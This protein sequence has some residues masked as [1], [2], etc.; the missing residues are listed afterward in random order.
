MLYNPQQ[1]FE[2]ELRD[3]RGDDCLVIELL[4]PVAAEL[5]RTQR[6]TSTHAPVRAHAYLQ[7]H[8]LARHLRARHVDPLPVEELA[9]DLLRRTV[10]ASVT[11]T[12]RG[13]TRRAHRELAEALKDTLW[14]RIGE[15]VG[16]AELAR[17]LAVS[18]F[19][20]MRVFREQTGFAIHDYRLQ[21]RLRVALER[22]AEG[23]DSPSVLA[24]ELGFAS[25]SHFTRQFRRSFGIA[26]SH[27]G[28]QDCASL[29]RGAELASSM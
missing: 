21:L 12:R 3:P 10:A 19:H 14:R 22:L 25:H 5:L 2:R 18:P 1:V 17:R 7:R 26:P 24:A 29:L 6:F 20:L 8:L 28:A 11:G 23:V 15:N 27:A 13:R 4:P 16:V 9:L